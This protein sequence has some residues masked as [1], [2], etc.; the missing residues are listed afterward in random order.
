MHRE[1]R[2]SRLALLFD[3]GGHEVAIIQVRL[4]TTLAQKVLRCSRRRYRLSVEI[5]CSLYAM[6]QWHQTDDV[7]FN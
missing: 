7:S 4:F 6:A 2:R 1:Q 5:P 3:I